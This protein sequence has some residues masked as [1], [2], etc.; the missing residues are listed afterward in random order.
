MA[1]ESQYFLFSLILL[2]LFFFV[3]NI[4]YPECDATQWIPLK[5]Y[6]INSDDMVELANYTVTEYNI[7]KKTNLVFKQ[8]LYGCKRAD[9]GLELSLVEEATDYGNCTTAVGNCYGVDGNYTAVVKVLD[10]YTKL[11]SFAKIE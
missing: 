11:E 5:S 10:W 8:L 7:E 3:P 1:I 6:E 4:A 2:S 9:S